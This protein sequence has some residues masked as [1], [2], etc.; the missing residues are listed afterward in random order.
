MTFGT[1]VKVTNLANGKST[2]CRVNDRGPYIDGRIIDL[3]P[4]TFS[5]LAPLEEGVIRVVIQW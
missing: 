4:H 1:V 3:S 5:H 2:T